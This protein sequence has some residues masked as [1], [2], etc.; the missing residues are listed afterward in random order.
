MTWV[1][2]PI[3]LLCGMTTDFREIDSAGSVSVIYDTDVS[4]GIIHTSFDFT[5]LKKGGCTEMIIANE[6]GANHFDLYRDSYG[7][8]LRGKG[9]GTWDEIFAHS[10][11]LVGSLDGISFS[12]NGFRGGRIF[13]GRELMA[14]RLA[15]SGLNY[16]L[17]GN[18]TSFAYDIKIGVVL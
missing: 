3:K 10:A 1:S 16:V 8:I 13:R 15:W 4:E 7:I 14:N 5:G 12:I 11:S 18:T 17:P 6:Q 2:Y 9:I